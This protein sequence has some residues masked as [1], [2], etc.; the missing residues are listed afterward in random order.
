ME[1]VGLAG[2]RFAPFTG[3]SLE[4]SATN[5]VLDHTKT[6]SISLKSVAA[7]MKAA[8][9]F[10]DCFSLSIAAKLLCRASSA[11]SAPAIT[12]SAFLIS[13]L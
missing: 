3:G 9:Y 13:N 10:F 2:G 4:L 12:S 6:V 1:F 11:A 7:V 8:A 5:N